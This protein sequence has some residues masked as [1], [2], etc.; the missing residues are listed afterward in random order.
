MTPSVIKDAAAKDKRA[1]ETRQYKRAIKGKCFPNEANEREE[2]EEKK[3]NEKQATEK[4][5]TTDIVG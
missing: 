1:S 2:K 3:K 4:G 5:K